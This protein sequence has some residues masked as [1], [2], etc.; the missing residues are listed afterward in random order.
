MNE[1][2]KTLKE[3]LKK[4]NY[5]LVKI[6]GAKQRFEILDQHK[7]S[8]GYLYDTQYE[9]ITTFP[10]T[11]PNVCIQ[12]AKKNLTKTRNSVTIG[13]ENS[14]ITFINYDLHTK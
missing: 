6:K 1:L 12:L 14:F 5:S 4:I 10:Y 11:T 13:K 2:L 9:S 3:K 7:Q 8:T